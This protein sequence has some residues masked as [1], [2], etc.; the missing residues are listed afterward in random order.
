MA[1]MAGAGETLLHPKLIEVAKKHGY[2]SFNEL[3][4]RAFGVLR[5]RANAV[6]V[7]PTGYGKTEAA[8]FPVLSALLEEGKVDGEVRALYVT[9]L[10]ALNRDVFV[11]MSRLARD[12]GISL[13]VRHGDTPQSARR[14]IA[15]NP[16]QILITTPETLQFIPVN[17][18]LR[19][20]LR[21]LE[22]V[23]VD[24]LHELISSKR[25]LQLSIALERLEEI[26]ERRLC[27]VGLSAT[28]K[29][30]FTAGLFLTGGR[31]F[32]IV[33]AKGGRQYE[34]GVVYSRA[35]EDAEERARLIADLLE[36][37]GSVLVFT[38][39]RDTA[40]S[41]ALRLS[42]LCGGAVAVHHGS[43]S[44]EQRTEVERKLKEGS[45]KCVVATSS[46]ELGIDV[47]HVKYV[48]QYMSPRQVNRLVQR[49]GRSAH[50]LGGIARGCIV[51]S[52]I[53][54]LLESLVIARRARDG[55]LEDAELEELAYD[56]L[57][58]Q[59]VGLVLERGEVSLE[60]AHRIVTKAYP[61]RSLGLSQLRSLVEFLAS[62]KLIR[63]DG[64]KLSRGP[65]SIRYYY[66]SAST[67]PDVESFD[68]VDVS[69]RKK[70]GSLDGDFVASVLS[71]GS[72]FVLGGKAWEVLKV[73]LEEGR[74]FVSPAENLEEAAIPAWI[75]EDLPVPFKVAREVGALRRRLATEPLS[76][77]AEE[78]RVGGEIL[79]EAKDYVERQLRALGVV[80]SDKDV[81][82]EVGNKLVV[83]HACL[84]TRANALL[85][86]LLSYALAK[87]YGVSSKY[88]FDAYRVA[89]TLSRD[90]S[91]DEIRGLLTE[92]LGKVLSDASSA[93]KGSSLYLWKLLHVCQRMGIVERGSKPKLPVGRLA[94]LFEG[95]P[96]D[97][98]TVKELLSTRLDSNTLKKFL[99]SLE[100]GRVRLH[101]IRVREFSPMAKSMFEKPYRAGVLTRGFEQLL[102]L[103]AVRKRLERSRL[104]LVCLH[105]LK[106]HR[107]IVV[108][109][110]GEDPKCPLCG[111]KVIAA[112]NPWDDNALRILEKWRRGEKLSEEEMRV[113]KNAQRSAILVMSYGRR[114]LL[115]LA[116][117]GIGPAVA[118]RVLSAS[119]SEDELLREIVK[120]EAEYVRTREYW[121]EPPRTPPRGA[122]KL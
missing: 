95:T 94:E 29:N 108:G 111:S 71:E 88:F 3:Q 15:E 21:E 48:V 121:R 50:F 2:L 103:D 97:E 60:E 26:S 41:L 51:A 77:L 22:W 47:G 54:D 56:V 4:L 49:V 79:L 66:E 59:L 18:K 83:V 114:A 107:E 119:R 64:R 92:K 89:L 82:V 113:V 42:K 80:P 33:E 7:A 90:L 63:F 84:G 23:I 14:K 43:L 104:L 69:S 1:V 106:W 20:A 44:R 52:D 55:D 28:V 78:Y 32:E 76:R 40:E 37:W 98:E 16:P 46:L 118:A 99:E 61:Y 5:R 8:V 86:L 17:P 91:S 112:L 25:G 72:R 38:N 27:R 58:H 96:V 105:C 34:I 57:A 116:G 31:Y 122:H 62:V 110:A 74:V 6:I 10:R 117:R 11:R 85:A 73:D 19:E 87:I 39:T 101:V 67:I 35:Y 109:E 75:G 70:V 81:V 53:D 115:C 9:P 36:R 24:E 100:S 120:A 12:L 30:P 102:V 68:V 65:R 45:L 93:I 13:E